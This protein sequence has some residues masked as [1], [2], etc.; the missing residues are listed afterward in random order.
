M[1]LENELVQEYECMSIR[2]PVWCS[3][4]SAAGIDGKEPRSELP[5]CPPNMLTHTGLRKVYIH[6][7]TQA[8]TC[9]AR[10][11]IHY[12]EKTVGTQHNY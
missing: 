10:K 7:R 11:F 1:E 6:T 12:M 2:L 3:W 8:S 4:A 9:I 5:W